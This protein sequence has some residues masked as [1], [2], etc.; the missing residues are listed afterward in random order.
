[1]N[2]PDPRILR[3]NTRQEL[4]ALREDAARQRAR[5]RLRQLERQ[6]LQLERA[7]IVTICLAA[8]VLGLL[9][10]LNLWRTLWTH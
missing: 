8:L 5:E 6:A 2:P 10:K 9:W 7:L 4:D 1:M 3:V